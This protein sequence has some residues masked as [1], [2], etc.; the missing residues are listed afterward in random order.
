MTYTELKNEIE[1]APMTWLPA[2]LIIVVATCVKRG[3]FKDADGL[4]ETVNRAMAP[5]T[6]EVANDERRKS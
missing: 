2:M 4:R 6:N 5:T 1:E 3:V